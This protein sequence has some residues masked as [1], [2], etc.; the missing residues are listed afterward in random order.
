MARA[1][2]GTR[3]SALARDCFC[4]SHSQSLYARQGG[5]RGT[6]SRQPIE[7]ER[8]TTNRGASRCACTRSRVYRGIKKGAVAN[9][10]CYCAP[11]YHRYRF[12]ASRYRTDGEIHH[13]DHT[14]ERPLDVDP[15]VLIERSRKGVPYERN[16]LSRRSLLIRY[17]KKNGTPTTNHH[18]RAAWLAPRKLCD[19]RD[20]IIERR[21]DKISRLGNEAFS[22][23]ACVIDRDG[24][25][26]AR[27]KWLD[28]IGIE[29]RR[30]GRIFSLNIHSATLFFY[31]LEMYAD[32]DHVNYKR[33]PFQGERQKLRLGPN[34]RKIASQKYVLL[35][36]EQAGFVICENPRV[37]CKINVPEEPVKKTRK[38]SR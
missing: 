29:S 21:T 16:F 37:S 36:R 17:R 32:S 11:P 33:K 7:E 1:K 27:Q 3:A 25:V 9:Q 4:S 8:R 13:V 14:L 28:I 15:R 12:S 6:S 34:Q 5:V 24:L 20:E 30:N 19:T 22:K 31:L 26:L 2:L 35:A 18:R 10:S 38:R 23:E